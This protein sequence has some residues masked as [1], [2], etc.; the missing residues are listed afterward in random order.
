MK[1]FE[2]HSINCPHCYRPSNYKVST[3]MKSKL[4]QI[5][6]FICYFC[7]EMFQA[8]IKKVKSDA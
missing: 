2:I 3:S 6:L 8:E 1:D 5:Q 4:Q 7:E